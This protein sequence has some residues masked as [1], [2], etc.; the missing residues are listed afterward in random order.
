MRG[1]R[2]KGRWTVGVVFRRR[3]GN[4]CGGGGGAHQATHT[5]TQITPNDDGSNYDARITRTIQDHSKQLRVTGWASNN[6]SLCQNSESI[7]SLK[8]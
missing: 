8:S 6:G 7:Q 5:H 4:L 2:G 3:L 1:F